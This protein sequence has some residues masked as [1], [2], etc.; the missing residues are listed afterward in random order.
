MLVLRPEM[1]QDCLPIQ[2]MV[3]AA[4]GQR[5]EAAIVAAIRNS[6]NFIPELS[7]VAEME[8]QIVGHILFS[9]VTIATE[10]GRVPAL[11]LA[12]LA[13]QPQYQRRGIGTQLVQMGLAR[14]QALGEGLV[15]VVGN[16]PFYQR[17]GFQPALPLGLR[18][19]LP[20]PEF[21]FLV[22]EL[23]PEA[24]RGLRGTVQYPAYFAAV[25]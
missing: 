19:S 22:G 11:A 10:T 23:Q 14:S 2:T 12:P 20:V 4:F 15:L 1:D 5:Q 6:T 3:T 25:A 13:V 9:R 16:P 24:L 17:F 7:L 18:P 21:A 8:R